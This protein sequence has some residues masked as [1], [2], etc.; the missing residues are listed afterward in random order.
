MAGAF[1]L[2]AEHDFSHAVYLLLTGSIFDYLAKLNGATG[3]GEA[4]LGA[5]HG[6]ASD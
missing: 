2:Q 6:T 5:P 3:Y 1:S 4:L